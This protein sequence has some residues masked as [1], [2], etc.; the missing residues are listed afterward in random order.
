MTC[1]RNTRGADKGIADECGLQPY[2]GSEKKS[3]KTQSLYSYL[4]TGLQNFQ[5]IIIM[6]RKL[7]ENGIPTAAGINYA[8]EESSTFDSLGLD[9]RLLQAVAQQNFSAPTLV[10]SKVVPLALEGK[11]ILG[12]MITV[13]KEM[14]IH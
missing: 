1:G 3:P 14:L 9:R 2:G 11:D 6:K 13:Y 5:L 10:Q 8:S 4:V 12:M 7:D